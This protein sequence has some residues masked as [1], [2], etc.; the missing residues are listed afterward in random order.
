[1]TNEKKDII[2]PPGESES[3]SPEQKI[4]FFPETRKI[5]ERTEST[6]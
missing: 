5:Q 6:R 3:L 4:D 1:M 2:Q